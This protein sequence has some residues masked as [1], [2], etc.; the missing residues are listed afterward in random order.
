MVT[1]ILPVTLSMHYSTNKTV[2]FSLPADK[3]YCM[4]S[5]AFCEA[6]SGCFKVKNVIA[7]TATACSGRSMNFKGKDYII[8]VP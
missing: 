8:H 1:C 6:H 4:K 7:L 3:P 2:Y 5:Y